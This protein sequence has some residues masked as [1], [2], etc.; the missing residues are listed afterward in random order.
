MHE[1]ESFEHTGSVNH[2]SRPFKAIGDIAI[3]S[4]AITA[5][6]AGYEAIHGKPRLLE[7]VVAAGVLAAGIIFRLGAEPPEAEY[8]TE[9]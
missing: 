5:I 9:D 8:Y 2:L 3:G 4:G 1:Q 7:A 6:H